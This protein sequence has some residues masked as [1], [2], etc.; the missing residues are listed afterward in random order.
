VNLCSAP[1]PSPELERPV[2]SARSRITNGW[3]RQKGQ[4]F[5]LGN[6]A[7]EPSKLK[8]Y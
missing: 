6:R 7:T 4:R 3:E 1:L 5:D 2:R 8:K